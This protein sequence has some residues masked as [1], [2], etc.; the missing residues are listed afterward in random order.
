MYIV[1]SQVRPLEDYKLL[2]TFK[3]GEQGI[4]D[5]TPYLSMGKYA[6]LRDE[7]LFNSTAVR[8]DTVEFFTLNASR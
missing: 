5:V 4:F 8:F 1:V 3:H 6:E 2:L 7:A